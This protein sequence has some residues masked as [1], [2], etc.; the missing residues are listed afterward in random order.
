MLKISSFEGSAIQNKQPKHK[1]LCN[2]T[3]YELHD[4]TL[5]NTKDIRISIQNWWLFFETH[6][7]KSLSSELTLLDGDRWCGKK[8]VLQQVCWCCVWELAVNDIT[9]M[10]CHI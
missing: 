10:I 7:D 8:K 3:F 5:Y 2:N 1:L 9:M 6:A 4:I